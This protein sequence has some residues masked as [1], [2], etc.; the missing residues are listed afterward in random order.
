MSL[1]AIT[2][3][4]SPVDTSVGVAS[5]GGQGFQDVLDQLRRNLAGSSET[6]SGTTAGASSSAS[7]S[8]SSTSSA[9]AA[10][11]EYLNKTPAQR[12]REAILKEMGITEEDIKN[13]P[14]EKQAAVEA[15]I[16]RKIRE[17]LLGKSEDGGDA[18]ANSGQPQAGTTAASGAA[19]AALAGSA[20]TG[21]SDENLGNSPGGQGG[22][23]ALILAALQSG[24]GPASAS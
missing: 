22:T 24:S 2:G 15:S 1:S 13:M 10:L 14:P 17:R 3:R 23:S 21:G 5:S 12:M 4:T 8:T 19:A 18:T 6:V 9:Y 7:S 11:T 20:N 16:A